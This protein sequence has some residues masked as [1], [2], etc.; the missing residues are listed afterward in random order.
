VLTDLPPHVAET[1]IGAIEHARQ[2]KIP[3]PTKLVTGRPLPPELCRIAMKA[4]AALPID[5]YATVAELQRD[6]EQFL[7]GG[8]WLET[9][10]FKP[11]AEII[12]QGD[13]AH[14]AFII[15]SGTCEAFQTSGG[16]RIPLQRMGPGEVFGETVFLA[17][18]RRMASVAAVDEVT[19]KV[20]TR[21]ALERELEG[22]AWVK[23]FVTVLA[24]RF[25]EASTK[26]TTLRHGPTEPAGGG[27]R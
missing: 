20:I 8:G 10:T 23:S 26:L 6:L 24:E 4:L 15:V 13:E 27:R 5:R 18:R 7:R 21:D 11:G 3:H 9:R 14:E 2:G 16:K 25:R 12:R 17:G 1:P 22:S 19:V